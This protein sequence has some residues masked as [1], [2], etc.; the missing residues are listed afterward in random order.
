MLWGSQKKKKEKR[1]KKKKEK[2]KSAKQD[3]LTDIENNHGFVVASG[4]G[5]GKAWEYG[6]SRCKL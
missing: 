2:K 6:V 1:K 3:R 4:E 5:G